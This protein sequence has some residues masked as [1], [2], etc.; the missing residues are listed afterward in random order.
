MSKTNTINELKKYLID[1]VFIFLLAN[2]NCFEFVEKYIGNKM[3]HK[4]LIWKKRKGKV[5]RLCFNYK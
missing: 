4:I 1:I 2:T 5:G 3:K